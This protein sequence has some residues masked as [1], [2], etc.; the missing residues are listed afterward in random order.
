MQIVLNEHKN[1][2]KEYQSE[3]ENFKQKQQDEKLGRKNIKLSRK[4]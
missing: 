4:I 2:R 3:I 1:H